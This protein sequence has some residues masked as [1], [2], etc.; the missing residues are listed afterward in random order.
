[1][2][3]DPDFDSLRDRDDYQKLHQRLLQELKKKGWTRKPATDHR[4]HAAGKIS[5]E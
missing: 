3:T 4:E 5:C 2:E 1:M